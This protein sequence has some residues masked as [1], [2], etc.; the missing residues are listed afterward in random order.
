MYAIE[1]IAIFEIVV[2]NRLDF[3]LLVLESTQRHLQKT[4]LAATSSG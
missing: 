2:C 1:P 3:I 4:I